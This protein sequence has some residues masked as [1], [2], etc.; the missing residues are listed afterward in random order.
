[1]NHSVYSVDGE[2]KIIEI[3]IDHDWLQLKTAK[4][5]ILLR[6]HAPLMP[7]PQLSTLCLHGIFHISILMTAPSHEKCHCISEV[8]VVL[9]ILNSIKKKN[10]KITRG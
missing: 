2:Q 10:G 5:V 6:F 4:S 9:V 8:A 7:L 3:T 1:M